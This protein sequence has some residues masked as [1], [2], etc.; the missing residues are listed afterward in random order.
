MVHAEPGDS[1]MIEVMKRIGRKRAVLERLE[2]LLVVARGVVL[3]RRHE[4]FL[5]RAAGRAFSTRAC[6]SAELNSSP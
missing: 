5:R 1:D 2:E 6:E 4:L 3:A